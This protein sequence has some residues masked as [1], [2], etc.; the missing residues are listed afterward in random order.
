MAITTNGTVKAW[1]DNGY[2]QLGD[3]SNNNQHTAVTVL[4]GLAAAKGIAAG[5][6]FSSF[7]I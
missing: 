5:G 1:R 6:G 3:G 7:A 4:N 2:R